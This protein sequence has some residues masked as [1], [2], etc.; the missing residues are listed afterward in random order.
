MGSVAANLS[1]HAVRLFS[2]LGR[3]RNRRLPRKRGFADHSEG[4]WELASDSESND[5]GGA[6]RNPEDSPTRAPALRHALER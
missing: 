6:G 5:T 3:Q 2:S 4:E 1:F